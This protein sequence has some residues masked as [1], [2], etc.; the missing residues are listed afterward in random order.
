MPA[1]RTRLL[2]L[3]TSWWTLF[4]GHC[5]ERSCEQRAARILSS[6]GFCFLSIN[7]QEW[8][9]LFNFRFFKLELVYSA[10]L[11]FGAERSESDAYVCVSSFLDSSPVEAITELGLV[12]VS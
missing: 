6:Q 5:K 12:L 7:N 9:F 2:R 8:N 10:V 11:A 3:L 1:A 4:P